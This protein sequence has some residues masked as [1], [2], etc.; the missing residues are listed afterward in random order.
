MIIEIPIIKGSELNKSDPFNQFAILMNKILSLPGVM[1]TQADGWMSPRWPGF[2]F[3]NSVQIERLLAFFGMFN[4]LYD[5]DPT[6]RGRPLS[7]KQWLVSYANVFNESGNFT[8]LIELGGFLYYMNLDPKNVNKISYNMMNGNIPAGKFLIGKGVKL[9]SETF[10]RFNSSGPFTVDDFQRYP[11][12]SEC[13]GCKFPGIGEFQITGR[14]NHLRCYGPIIKNFYAK[15]IDQISTKNYWSLIVNDPRILASGQRNFYISPNTNKPYVSYQGLSD[16][17]TALM[18]QVAGAGYFSYHNAMI[19]RAALFTKALSKIPV[20]VVQVECNDVT[21]KSYTLTD[22][23]RD[24][25]SLVN[26]LK[27]S[28][29]LTSAAERNKNVID[30]FNE[31]FY[32][33][34]N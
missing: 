32:L 16:D 7:I 1:A 29:N 3:K 5:A 11:L 18:K 22:L 27:D 9:D 6:R 24:A 15:S 19:N 10:R 28:L 13:D 14:Y 4:Q 26:N 20:S 8:Q 17:N 31:D 25:L 33:K 34:M 12:L 30:K 21:N 2:Y 23:S